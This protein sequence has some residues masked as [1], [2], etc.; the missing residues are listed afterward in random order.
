MSRAEVLRERVQEAIHVCQAL[1]EDEEVASTVEAVVEAIVASISNGGKVLLCGNGG[2]A[3]DAQHLAA[4]LVG[5]FCLDRQP[6]PA[7]AL[8]DNIAAVTAVGND[9]DYADVFS[10]AVRGFG[11]P[12]D[13][14]IGL[15]TS[16]RSQNVIEALEAGRD[17]GLVT[18]AL[19]GEPGSPMEQA[20]Q[21]VLG[22]PG[23]NTARIQ[24]GQM[25]LGH[26]IFELVERELASSGLN[27]GRSRLSR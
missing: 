19:V 24:E 27:A 21:Y 4:E 7:L 25:L 17:R 23:P 18:I 20:C 22:I 13:V 2:S 12:G 15:S 16:G 14:L 10:R 9:F 8:S 5:R 3:A 6:Y 1:L 26:T 11:N